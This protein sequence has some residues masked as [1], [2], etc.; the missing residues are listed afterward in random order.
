MSICGTE[1]S[2][3]GTGSTLV[4]TSSLFP[5]LYY[6]KWALKIFEDSP[7]LHL[8]EEKKNRRDETIKTKWKSWFLKLIAALQRRDVKS[9]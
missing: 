2:C 9:M 5:L 7:S 1:H 4:A 3:Q 8:K 6:F